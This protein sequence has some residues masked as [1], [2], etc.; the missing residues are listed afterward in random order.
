VVAEVAGLSLFVLSM[1]IASLVSFKHDFTIVV[2]KTGFHLGDIAIEF[3]LVP[4]VSSH[5]RD[6]LVGILFCNLLLYKL[7]LVLG[8]GFGSIALSRGCKTLT[9]TE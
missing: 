1:L 3:L 9:L 6:S 8:N 7:L 4:F 5:Q 2:Q